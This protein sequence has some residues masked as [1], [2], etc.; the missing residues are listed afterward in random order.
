MSGEKRKQ[1]LE[2]PILTSLVV[3]A[4]PIVFT[5]LLQTAYQLTDA[6]WVGRLGGE[7][8]AAVSVVFPISFLAIALG[9]G[10]SIAASTLV[11]QAAGAGRISEVRHAASQSLL[12]AMVMGLSLGA[13]GFVLSPLILDWMGVPKE[14][15]PSALAVMKV[16]FLTTPFTFI[17]MTY[18]SLM[19]GVGE[20]TRPMYIVLSTVLLNAVID[21]FLI[22]GWGPVPAF[23]V[24][25][26]S[27]ATFFTQGLSALVAITILAR[28]SH[29]VQAKLSEMR[30]DWPLI[31][32][33]SALGVPTSAEQA[34]RSLAFVIMTV[35]VVAYGTT[36]VA[37]YGVGANVMMVVLIPALGLSMAVA[38]LVGQSIGAGK[39]ARASAAVRVGSALSFGLLALAGLIA[40]I[41]AR[42]I[43]GF[44][45]SPEA[46][47]VTA[48]SIA[49]VHV[50]T[51]SFGLVGL[52]MVFF[53][54]F[55]A[56]GRPGLA[57][58]LTLV[59]QWGVQVPV[60]LLLSK[61]T[62]LGVEGIWWAGPISQVVAVI[63]AAT[64]YFRGSW[65]KQVLTKEEQL[66]ERVAE[67]IL[68]EEGVRKV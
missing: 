25:G 31:K 29:G 11:A 40:Y 64:W 52:Q 67:E 8:V 38:A 42:P 24:V 12:L 51:L 13:V 55:R 4:V 56:A 53:G 57:F 14:V 35:L 61:Y 6:F 28:G 10:F 45:V 43:V 3:L 60:A 17:F 21:P 1:L 46:V 9:M 50:A 18:Q 44:F 39:I 36:E 54:A 16:A 47:E 33:L 66:A 37:A 26:A 23:G 59:A 48:R 5:N 20:V 34:A 22:F 68:I 32:R 65:Q 63:L 19:R 30:P 27:W 7:A 62:S 41:F 58:T 49:F 2:G 15:Y